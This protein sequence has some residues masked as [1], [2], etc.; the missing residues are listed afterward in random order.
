MYFVKSLLYKSN[1]G[2]LSKKKKKRVKYRYNLIGAL[3]FNLEGGV[4]IKKKYMVLILGPTRAACLVSVRLAHLR[5][6]PS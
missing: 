5:P 3:T 2:T 4:K 6:T 1:I